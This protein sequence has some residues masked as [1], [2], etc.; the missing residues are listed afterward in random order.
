MNIDFIS[1]TTNQPEKQSMFIENSLTIL[2]NCKFNKKI[3]GVDMVPGGNLETNFVNFL[4]EHSFSADYHSGLGMVNN[5][6][7]VIN[8]LDSEWVLYAEDDVR[9]NKNIDFS[10]L[11]KFVEKKTNKKVGIIDFMAARGIGFSEDI[12]VQ[13]KRNAL[14]K[15]SYLKHKDMQ[16]WV[17]DA[18][19]V[20][21]FFINFPILLIKREIFQKCFFEA[22]E[23]FKNHQI[24]TGFTAAFSKL[25]FIEEYIKI[26]IFSNLPDFTTAKNAS[27]KDISFNYFN[28]L[29]FIDNK[30]TMSGLDFSSNFT[31]DMP[32]TQIYSF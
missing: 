6:N 19:T 9:L 21:H 32:W 27:A 10:K 17:R 1:I 31:L 16:I 29:L 26:H 25:N 3:V 2:N 12:S 30:D 14:K 22:K 28:N 24:E 20:D 15:S 23:N 4:S 13:F 5:L 18:D 8:Q 7:S 11:L